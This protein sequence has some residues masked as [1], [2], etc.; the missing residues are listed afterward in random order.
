MLIVFGAIS[1][2]GTDV[3]TGVEPLIAAVASIGGGMTVAIEVAVGEGIGVSV[4]GIVEVAEGIGMEVAVEVAVGFG[5]RVTIE[6]GVGLGVNVGARVGGSCVRVGGAG[7]EDG[8]GAA[9]DG[10]ASSGTV[11]IKVGNT[12]MDLGLPLAKNA[13]VKVPRTTSIRAEKNTH[14]L[15]VT[16]NPLSAGHRAYSTPAMEGP[17]SHYLP[18]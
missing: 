7:V 15:R 9:V 16:L 3:G 17:P 10:C 14:L 4:G 8:R 6:V 11:G 18:F 13:P 2:I 5:V 12:K 1:T